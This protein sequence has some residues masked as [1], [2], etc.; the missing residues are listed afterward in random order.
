MPLLQVLVIRQALQQSVR[1]SSAS[2]ISFSYLH[3]VILEATAM[4]TVFVLESLATPRLRLLEVHSGYTQASAADL[5]QFSLVVG[6]CARLTTYRTVEI[7]YDATSIHA[8][9]F[10]EVVGCDDAPSEPH[11]VHLSLES[12][13]IA[14]RDTTRMT[15]SFLEFLRRLS[16]PHVQSL[17]FIFGGDGV[18]RIPVRIWTEILLMYR[19]VQHLNVYGTLPTGLLD[20]FLQHPTH[21]PGAHDCHCRAVLPSLRSV[22][23]TVDCE[24][25]DVT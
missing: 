4:H 23:L 2:R 11:V 13:S 25:Y 19:G 17:Y 1:P 22:V 20:A 6:A 14:S 7:H 18:D 8:F 16:L 9:G 24:F 10:P 3:T 21:S 15:S 5:N 12:A